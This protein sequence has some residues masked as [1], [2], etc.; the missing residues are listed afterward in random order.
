M[1]A[2]L[3][4]GGVGARLRPLTDAMP[5]PLLPIGDSSALDTALRCLRRGGV[6]RVFVAAGYRADMVRAFVEDGSRWDLDVQVSVEEKPLGTAGPLALLRPQLCE[7]FILMNGDV[8]TTLDFGRFRRQAS[9]SRAALT[10]VTTTISIDLAYGRVTGT[11]NRI[12]AVEEKPELS[13]EVLA[14]IYL[15]RPA[16]LNVIPD[17]QPFGVDEL[18]EALLQRGCGVHRYAADAYW[19]DIG[20]PADYEAAQDEYSLLFARKV[21]TVDRGRSRIAAA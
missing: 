20:Q 13:A 3:L 8:L 19:R 6:T 16:A 5:K 1:D 11:G 14:G 18:I 12:D 15:L 21:R 2:V 4:A 10:A 9:A 7:P 17:D